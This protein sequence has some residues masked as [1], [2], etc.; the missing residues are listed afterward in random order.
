MYICVYFLL[1]DSNL[2]SDDHSN[3]GTKAE[4]E[5]I[6]MLSNNAKVCCFLDLFVMFKTRAA[7]FERN[8]KPRG[9][10]EWF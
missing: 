3:V 8:L 6:I 2:K 9:A 1:K 10:A 7:V 4:Y 5:F